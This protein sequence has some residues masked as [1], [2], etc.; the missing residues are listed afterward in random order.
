MQMWG[1]EYRTTMVCIDSYEDRIPKGRLYNRFAPEG[2]A[3][4]GVMD[5]L[6]KME[7]MLDQ[8]QFPQ[9]FAA[10]RSFSSESEK[11]WGTP[12][13][14]ETQTQTGSCGTLALRI[15]FRQNASWQGSVTWL[16]GK[17]EESFR[18]VLEL[19]FLLDSAAAAMEQR[20]DT[21][22]NFRW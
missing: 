18:S 9:A 4:R 17:R 19:L 20:N 2:V 16:E 21:I 8:M 5:F 14:L 1:N 10:V 13:A 11:S 12:T 7:D 15:L 3:F 6:K 22:Q